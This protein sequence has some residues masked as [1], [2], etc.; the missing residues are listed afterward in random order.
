MSEQQ[1][2]NQPWTD[3]QV[4]AQVQQFTERF[5]SDAAFQEKVRQ[6]PIAVLRAEG[7]CKRALS[8]LIPALGVEPDVSGYKW[9]SPNCGTSNEK[10][11]GCMGVRG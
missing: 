8:E 5:N 7:V 6:D 10:N 3:E 4:Q 1:Q 2:T 11:P 9:D